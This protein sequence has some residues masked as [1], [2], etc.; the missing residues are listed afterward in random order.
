MS[1]K[2]I[3]LMNP[4]FLNKQT[5]GTQMLA[6]GLHIE[7]YLRPRNVTVRG[8]LNLEHQASTSYHA[9]RADRSVSG[10]T[11]IDGG[12]N[13][14]ND[15]TLSIDTSWM[16]SNYIP[17]TKDSTVHASVNINTNSGA[18]PFIISRTGR[19]D[20]ETAEHYISDG[21]YTIDYSNDETGSDIRFF[22]RN[23]D[24]ENGSDGSNASEYSF[25]ISARYNGVFATLDGNEMWHEGNFTPSDKADTYKP[26][27]EPNIT[28]GNEL[29]LSSASSYAYVQAGTSDKTDGTMRLTGWGSNYMDLLDIIS[30]HT[31]VYGNMEVNGTATFDDPSRALKVQNGWMEF[32]DDRGSYSKFVTVSGDNY[33][34]GGG[35]LLIGNNTESTDPLFTIQQDNRV[36]IREVNPDALFHVNNNGST[37]PPFYV[38]A[39]DYPGTQTLFNHTGS[40]NHQ[41]F[42]IIKSND[43]TDAESY[44]IL[45]VGRDDSRDGEGA[46]YAI[47]MKNSAGNWTTYG[48]IGAHIVSNSS[49]AEEG[50][51]TI[52]TTDSGAERSGKVT[53]LPNGNVGIGD[54]NPDTKLTVA[55]SMRLHGWSEMVFENN[56]WGSIQQG[57]FTDPLDR[58]VGGNDMA[59]STRYS[60]SSASRAV[61]QMWHD[62]GGT[63]FWTGTQNGNRRIM[64]LYEDGNLDV[65]GS[66]IKVESG[67]N[68]EHYLYLKRDT[69]HSWKIRNNGGD[70]IINGGSSYADYERL[71][72]DSNGDIGVGGI[73]PGQGYLMEFEQV[74][75]PGD[76]NPTI[77][78]RG[79]TSNNGTNEGGGAGI[80]FRTSTTSGFGPIIAGVRRYGGNGDFVIKTGG[81]TPSE[82]FRIEHTGNVGIG[83]ATPSDK[84]HVDGG[85]R[86]ES[87]IHI[88]GE[89]S[90]YTL[91]RFERHNQGN[92]DAS[93]NI[94]L[95]YGQ[96]TLGPYSVS[97]TANRLFVINQNHNIGINRPNGTNNA[98]S[99][100]HVGGRTESDD[101]FK[102][103][104]YEITHNT[105]QDSLDI[106]YVG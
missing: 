95:V 106:M 56:A 31:R 25:K 99:E 51:V 24:V 73:T 75:T 69:G 50:A 63:T 67:G 81:R 68:E 98:D 11:G 79:V 37:A 60:G 70:L 5:T 84:L 82:R 90:D 33:G 32:A 23:K 17:R 47:D 53:V 46:M 18:A 16:D 89:D 45:G 30:D 100:L 66:H 12:G 3:Q 58:S 87:G 52:Y 44:R 49:G 104:N 80:Q 64:R 22:L 9:V 13:L 93:W 28:I 96:F 10:G 76:V 26:H 2:R 71:R 94:G 55:G 105:D 86:F 92:Y 39:G 6:G 1:D 15:R 34:S 8:D 72:I 43:S 36:G 27:F 38:D 102:T 103:G 14:L 91:L 85:A 88:R 41:P 65:N 54:S 7:G 4:H 78:L 77:G 48:G 21:A 40:Q 101:G 83:T 74:G 62:A 42:R 35:K 19:R 97:S 20:K 59:L 29:R 61:N 57:S